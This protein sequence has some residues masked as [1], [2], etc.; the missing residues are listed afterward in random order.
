[1]IP[2]KRNQNLD[3]AL[4]TKEESIVPVLGSAPYSHTYCCVGFLVKV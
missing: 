2:L 3:L 4:G 1:M